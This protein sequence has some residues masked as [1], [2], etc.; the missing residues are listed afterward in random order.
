M[1]KSKTFLTHQNK[2]K[3][4]PVVGKA[5]FGSCLA[6]HAVGKEGNEFAPPLDGGKNRGIEHLLTAIISPDDA[7]E[8][9]FGLYF[10][11]TKDGSVIEGYL[12][13]NDSNGIT[14]GQAGGSKLFVAKNNIHSHG[15]VNGRSF[16]PRTF[17]NLPAQSLI[18]ISAYIK[19]LE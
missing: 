5:I 13:K 11:T 1:R 16:M 19:T 12:V 7:V 10:V 14:I 18:D 15:G 17:G 3:G 2:L 8:G 6:C 4:N 9:A